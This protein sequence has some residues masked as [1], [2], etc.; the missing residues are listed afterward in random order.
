M[1]SE[2]VLSRNLFQ[3]SSQESAFFQLFETKEIDSWDLGV[4]EKKQFIVFLSDV[5]GG[6]KY[7]FLKK[8]S[9]S[10]DIKMEEKKLL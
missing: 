2:S 4:E 7:H 1:V 5:K 9:E 3:K 6:K 8:R 10:V